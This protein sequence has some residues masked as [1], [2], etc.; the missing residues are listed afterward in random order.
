MGDSPVAAMSA[1]TA[2]FNDGRESARQGRCRCAGEKLGGGDRS[3]TGDRGFAVRTGKH[4]HKCPIMWSYVI[5]NHPG[6]ESEKVPLC[7]H[8]GAASRAN[9]GVVWIIYADGSREA[10]WSSW[11]GSLPSA[12][13]RRYV[14]AL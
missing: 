3:R 6:W 9:C 2:T 14:G 12:P 11:F 10:S 8:S 7:S 5:R 4:R 13:C 1:H